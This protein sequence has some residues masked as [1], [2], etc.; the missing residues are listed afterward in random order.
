[1]TNFFDMK[2]RYAKEYVDDVIAEIKHD[3]EAE[4][5]RS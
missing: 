5:N 2:S 3:L 1:M 4:E